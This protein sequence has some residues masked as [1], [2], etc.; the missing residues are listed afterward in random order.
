[1]RNKDP[2][3]RCLHGIMLGEVH[4][5]LVRL[6]SVEGAWRPSHIDDPPFVLF[7]PQLFF[8]YVC[9]GLKKKLLQNYDE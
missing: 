1:M 6:A 7:H 9:S 2:D 3:L 8:I 4:L 5:Q